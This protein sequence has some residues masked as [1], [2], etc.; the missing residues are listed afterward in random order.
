VNVPDQ[1]IREICASENITGQ[2][3]LALYGNDSN[4]KYPSLVSMQQA[5]QKTLTNKGWDVSYDNTV[6]ALRFTRPG[7]SGTATFIQS[8][9][10]QQVNVV[11]RAT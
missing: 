3:F 1:P 4:G 11:L 7:W 9:H 8:D 5:W 6:N 2:G 10:M